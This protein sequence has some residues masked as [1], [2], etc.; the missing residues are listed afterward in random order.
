MRVLASLVAALAVSS[1]S[2]T[3]GPAPNPAPNPHPPAPPHDVIIQLRPN[4]SAASLDAL[5]S[6]LATTTTTPSG[7][8]H[9]YVAVFRGAAARVTP[10]QRAALDA[11][12]LVAAVHDDHDVNVTLRGEGAVKAGGGGGHAAGGGPPVPWHLD[13]L[14]QRRLPLD[15][16]YRYPGLGTGV[17]VY[18]VDT[19]R[20]GKE[21][22]GGAKLTAACA[23][24]PSPPPPSL[25]SHR[26]SAKTTTNF[27]T[28]PAPPRPAPPPPAPSTDGPPLT[29]PPPTTPPPPPTTATATAPTS[30]PSWAD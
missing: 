3:P 20:K 13:R 29:A 30:P 18:V 1:A 25:S 11:D 26:A 5:C 14:D 28:C 4:A 16:R 23:V 12:P 22:G 27:T 19:V 6:S 24:V 15:G 8:G 21:E 10:A 17:T 7:C 9:R 2:P